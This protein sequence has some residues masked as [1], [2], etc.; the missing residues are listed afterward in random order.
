MVGDVRPHQEERMPKKRLNKKD[1]EKMK[2]MSRGYFVMVGGKLETV[3]INDPMRGHIFLE[4]RNTVTYEDIMQENMQS[5]E[6]SSIPQKTVEKKTW[7]PSKKRKQ[8]DGESE[9]QQ[10][11]HQDKD[12]THATPKNTCSKKKKTDEGQ[13][14]TQKEKTD[15]GQKQTQKKKQ[16]QV[17]K[18]AKV[19]STAPANV[20]AVLEDDNENE[21]ETHKRLFNVIT[22]ETPELKELKEELINVKTHAEMMMTEM[23]NFKI[24]VSENVN[25]LK[26]HITSELERFRYEP[27]RRFSGNSLDF[28]FKDMLAEQDLTAQSLV[29]NTCL[30]QSTSS[31]ES[32]NNTSK[33]VIHA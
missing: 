3:N 14:Q 19:H 21:N 9:G 24:M 25:S 31:T 23:R 8:G 5:E 13:R 26:A 17:K 2:N 10:E 20:V 22:E 16:N 33:S 4:N 28:S 12:T 30:P 6:C 15:E 11:I 27:C 32:Y 7:G 29:N 18:A 1:I